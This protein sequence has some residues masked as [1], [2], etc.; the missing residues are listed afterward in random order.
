[1][2]IPPFLLLAALGLAAPLQGA[3]QFRT[4]PTVVR[5][6]GFGASVAASETV[7]AVGAPLDDTKGVDA[8][9]VY[10]FNAATGVFKKK[11]FAYG[12]AAGQKFGAA[13]AITGNTLAVGMPGSQ[14]GAGGMVWYNAN[15]GS[16]V[17]IFYGGQL[18]PS[19]GF[20]HSIAASGPIIVV[21]VPGKSVLVDPT[22]EDTLN[23]DAVNH[24]NA[25]IVVAMDV[26]D[27]FGSKTLTATL[28]ATDERMGDS[29]AISGNLVLM[30][31][32]M[33]TGGAGAEQGAVHFCDISSPARQLQANRLIEAADAAP[34]DHFGASVAIEGAEAF[35]GAPD[36]GGS[37]GA[38]YW[39]DLIGDAERMKIVG[40]AGAKY[41]AGLAVEG[42]VLLVGAPGSNSPVGAGVVGA[43]RAEMLD[44]SNGA[45][46]LGFLDP[47]APGQNAGMGSALALAGRTA[48]AAA[49]GETEGGLVQGAAYIF[50]PILKPMPFAE[51]YRKG[52]YAPGV[53]GGFLGAATQMLV[54]PTFVPFVQI[55]TTGKKGEGVWDFATGAML[56]T[57]KTGDVFA[58]AATVADIL[59]SSN[60]SHR[61]AVTTA[62]GAGT[63]VTAASDI[64]LFLH[65][66]TGSHLLLREGDVLSGLGNT[67]V[68]TLG[69]IRQDVQFTAASFKLAQKTAGVTKAN[70][71]V[72]M[73]HRP[74]LGTWTESSIFVR[75]GVL[76]VTGGDVYGEILPAQAINGGSET[77]DGSMS[78]IAA[79][80]SAA[81]T[82]QAAFHEST[83]DPV[84][85]KGSPA[86][87][88]GNF[89]SFIGI[90]NNGPHYLLRATIN[91]TGT[92]S[93]TNE[94]LW[95]D[96]NG[97]QELV[98]RKGTAL[99]G[100]PGGV[101]IKQFLNYALLGS[102]KVIVRCVLSGTGVK[103][104]ND[105]AVI[106]ISTTGDASILLREGDPVS[107]Y[108][109]G[110]INVIQRFDVSDAGTFQALCTISTAATGT[111]L[112]LYEGSSEPQAIPGLALAKPIIR[113]G[114]AFDVDG[115]EVVKSIKIAPAISADGA[116][117]NGLPRS[118]RDDGPLPVSIFCLQ[119]TDN[120]EVVYQRN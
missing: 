79:L 3:Y 62:K 56:A 45:A 29:V 64:G 82:N 98:A 119:Y 8:G 83:S 117:L 89:S 4:V 41:G 25:G 61:Y 105:N 57:Q 110:V 37:A 94:G 7:I 74:A 9:A 46:S 92:S 88:G 99:A 13:V 19:A 49:P 93:A 14:N 85:R 67:K 84:A 35:V 71:C 68:A 31:A 66:S 112:V 106:V 26:R 69:S 73:K 27:P 34:G 33:H 101:T 5:E 96:R 38:V 51:V 81:A 75:E 102:G 30:G 23:G 109:G 113:K 58:G 36:R 20:G 48:V 52:S 53:N 12:A 42:T 39:L 72:L 95:S 78:W 50:T 100:L 6:D 54:G 116:L 11:I 22:P 87:G 2:K 1:M 24:P 115:A 16:P 97:S 86:P 17:G 10:L 63:G 44:L 114:A 15:T 120:R 103:T 77:L 43:G 90:T 40:T 32:P 60:N 108:G 55:P 76:P 59:V 70:D 80:V 65:D 111:D 107:G 21:G 47:A 118:L 18:G 104:T 91:G 28:P